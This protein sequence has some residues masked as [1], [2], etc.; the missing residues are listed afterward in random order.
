MNA[1]G[2]LRSGKFNDM[3]QEWQDNG[4]VII[5]LVKRG[6]GKVHRL[7]VRDLYGD[8]EKVLWQKTFKEGKNEVDT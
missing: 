4:T 2:T 1:I 8:K 6:E 5:T 7:H 3:S